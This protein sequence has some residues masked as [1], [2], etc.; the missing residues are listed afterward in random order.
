MSEKKM[1]LGQAIDQITDALESLG[2]GARQTAINAAC[3]H[4]GIS[5]PTAST[6][7]TPAANLASALQSS[8]PA[9]A[10]A[11]AATPA[12]ANKIVD[13]RTLKEEKA[14][15]SASQMACVVAYY[16]QELAP[17]KDRK[18]TVSAKDLE[19]YFK[20]AQ[21]KL[22]KTMSQLLPDAK[23]SGYFDSAAGKGE[24]ALNAVGYN[25]VAHSLPKKAAK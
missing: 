18:N 1:T 8:S 20:Q 11:Q 24:Y 2:E 7:S 23:A 17:E 3:E 21:F 16:L 6:S 10:A 15:S 19:K 13:I 22:P 9:A 5:S 4:L 14:P 25:L 12:V